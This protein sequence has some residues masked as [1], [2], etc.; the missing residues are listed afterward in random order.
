MRCGAVFCGRL[1][2]YYPPEVHTEGGKRTSQASVGGPSHLE[3]RTRQTATFP[4]L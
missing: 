2:L 3:L 4:A 1:A